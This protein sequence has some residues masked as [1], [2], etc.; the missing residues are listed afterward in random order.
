MKHILL[1]ALALAALPLAGFAQSS[2]VPLR[3]S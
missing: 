2:A 1:A 3:I